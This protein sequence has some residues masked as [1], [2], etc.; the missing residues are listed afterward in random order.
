MTSGCWTRERAPMDRAARGA[1]RR[2]ARAALALAMVLA[3]VGIAG[4]APAQQAPQACT[5]CAGGEFFPVTPTRIFDTRDGTGGRGVPLPFG[6][7]AN[8]AVTNVAGVP[9]SGVLA[10]ALNVTVD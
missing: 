6:Q 2:V 1:S 3:T 7:S 8:V 9:A 5:L 4:P 10:V